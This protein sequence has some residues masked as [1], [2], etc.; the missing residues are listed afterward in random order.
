MINKTK[1]HSPI[2]YFED[3]IRNNVKIK[4]NLPVIFLAGPIRNAP[5]WQDKAIKIF[6]E[7]NK[8]LFIASPRREINP[9]LIK[10]IEQDNPSNYQTFERQR[11]WEQYY[12]YFASKNGCIIFYLPKEAEKEDSNKVYGHITM[13]E[14]GEWIARRKAN[15]NI[16][17]VIGTD[18]EFPEWS[19]IKFEIETEIP[20]VPICYSLEETIK[21]A[22]DLF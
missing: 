9:D 15:P 21:T 7:E 18:G 8:E 10:F 19:T 16:N 3:K 13:M 1:I 12:L 4:P 6:I 14:L 11:A 2:S 20:E 17:L 5:K 22:L